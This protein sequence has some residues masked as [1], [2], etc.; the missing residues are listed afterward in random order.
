M[1]IRLAAEKDI[2]SLL[3]LLSQVLAVH[4]QIR[5]DL[6]V[7]GMTKYGEEDLKKIL[8]AKNTPVFVA[9]GEDGRIRGYVFCRLEEPAHARHMRPVRTM[10]ID[11]LCVDESARHQGIGKLLF[12]FVREEA[13][14]SRCE[15]VT[16]HVWEGNESA[17]RFY[18]SMGMRPRETLMELDVEKTE[19]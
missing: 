9:A 7:D 2:P 10:F 12:E 6:F 15:T 16:L 19:K 11:D 13:K 4:A 14:R 8:A 1:I 18:E 5:P 3:E 17:R